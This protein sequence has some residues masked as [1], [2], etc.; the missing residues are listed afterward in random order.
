MNLERQLLEEFGTTT[1]S[2]RNPT[3]K[4]LGWK[5]AEDKRDWKAEDRMDAPERTSGRQMW[6]NPQQG[7]QFEEGACV[8]AGWWGY[9]NSE[10]FP[11][12]YANNLLFAIYEAA[13]KADEW[14]GENYSGTSVRAGAKVVKYGHV[15]AVGKHINGYAFTDQAHTAAMHV[16]NF[17][18]VVIGV[19]WMDGMDRVDAEGFIHPTGSV[20]GGHCVVVDGVVWDVEDRVDH[21]RIRNSWG[22]D[23]GFNG[24]CRIKASDL[25]HLFDRGGTACL[26]VEV[27]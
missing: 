26:A 13:Q 17:A 6:A 18:P 24:R 15:P 12:A 22:L 11:H 8:G 2:D 19:D 16:L 27:S 1:F 3:H 9:L 4:R 14:P 7:N 10:P 21:F 20:R 23:W 5:P 25:Q